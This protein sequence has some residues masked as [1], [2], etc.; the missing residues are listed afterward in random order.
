[1]EQL[2]QDSAVPFPPTTLD[3]VDAPGVEPAV[4]EVAERLDVVRLHTDQ[5][6]EGSASSDYR[7][8]A[9]R[10]LAP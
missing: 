5:R 7:L 8:G 2:Q 9:G 6:L 4:D 3:P 10:Y 1:M